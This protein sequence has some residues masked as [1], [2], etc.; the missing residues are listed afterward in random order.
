MPDV[1]DD[2]HTRTDLQRPEGIFN[3][4]DPGFDE[5]LAGVHLHDDLVHVR[6][7]LSSK[8]SH[9]QELMTAV[10]PAD[11]DRHVARGGRR[12]LAAAIAPPSAVTR[13]LAGAGGGRTLGTEPHSEWLRPLPPLQKEGEPAK[14]G[15]GFRNLGFKRGENLEERLKTH[16]TMAKR[17]CETG[18]QRNV[19]RMND[20]ERWVMNECVDRG[21]L[22]TTV[23]RDQYEPLC[24]NHVT[25]S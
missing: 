3:A 20:A 13:H 9:K 8:H 19:L 11:G 4:V 16:S 12:R 10:A 18:F 5:Q 7:R 2:S 25:R 15:R 17:T 6:L 24:G 1:P 22:K 21:H 23:P 14:L